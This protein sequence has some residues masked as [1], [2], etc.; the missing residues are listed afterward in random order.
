MTTTG[1][2]KPAY[3]RVSEAAAT[4]AT[5]PW[6]ALPRL[7]DLMQRHPCAICDASS[8]P[9]PKLEMK[10]ALKVA[11]DLAASDAQRAEI[12]AG[13]LHLSQF[14]EGVGAEPINGDFPAT[15][16]P[17]ESAALINRWVPWS[18]LCQEDKWSL[19]VELMD[20]KKQRLTKSAAQAA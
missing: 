1:D 5:N 10:I 12:E 3:A 6:E 2:D 18:D 15:A 17:A 11:W 4:S 13:F 7:R 14:Q 8:L 20:F 9:L 19:W 16:D